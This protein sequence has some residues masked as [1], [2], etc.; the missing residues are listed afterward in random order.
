MHWSINH[1]TNKLHLVEQYVA[2]YPKILHIIAISE[3][4]LTTSNFST[5]NLN[6]YH[7]THSVRQ[8]TSGGG[9]S[10]FVHESICEIAPKVLVDIVTLDL[11]HF[12]VL[13]ISSANTIV[14]V[15]YR[16]PNSI[17]FDRRINTFLEELDQFCLIHPQCML[18]SDFNLNQLDDGL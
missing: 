6:G 8:N 10:I 14:A 17:D 13:E 4:W 12:L 2:C 9:I 11:N 1:L 16:R 3:T 18:M 5:Y 7:V 15:P